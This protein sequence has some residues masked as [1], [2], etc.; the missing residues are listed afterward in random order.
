MMGGEITTQE[1][2]RMR[3]KLPAPADIAFLLQLLREAYEEKTWHGPNLRQALRGVPAREVSWRPGRNC[4]NIWEE[5]THAAYWKY[6]A[7][8]RLLGER[9][10]S[11]ALKGRNFFPSPQPASETAWRAALEL[12]D[13]E[14]RKLVAVVADPRH[15]AV[16]RK[17]TKMVLGI[18]YHD[19]Y[20]AGQ[21][22][23]LRRLQESKRT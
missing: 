17:R 20:H 16:V 11:F 19:V 23:L 3:R 2:N 6:M 14:H 10:P 7:R 9:N 1:E 5:T 13:T 4:H 15:A 22:R 8:K 21:I 18:A 12:L